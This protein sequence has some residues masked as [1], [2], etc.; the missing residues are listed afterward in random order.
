MCVSFSS[1]YSKFWQNFD[2]R[3]S[4]HWI[5]L[6][7]NCVTVQKNSSSLI[8]IKEEFKR[9]KG[10]FTW[11]IRKKD[12]FYTP[13]PTRTQKCMEK[14]SKYM[15]RMLSS[16]SSVLPLNCV[17]IMWMTGRP[18]ILP[19]IITMDLK[20]HKKVNYLNRSTQKRRNILS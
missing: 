12:E 7:L 20:R 8:T 2:V 18:P 4:N 9:A 19:N 3:S 16:D 10:P 6:L 5:G 11:Y 1:L 13:R 15:D 14:M 17:R